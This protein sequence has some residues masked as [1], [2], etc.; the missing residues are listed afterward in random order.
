MTD[1]DEPITA[2]EVIER[3][4]EINRREAEREQELEYDWGGDGSDLHEP[5]RAHVEAALVL[6]DADYAPPLD[7]LLRMGDPRS[8][9]DL[10]ERIAALDLTQAHV[11]D[12]VRMARDRELNIAMSDSDEV[13]APIHALSALEHLD[14]SGV[15]SELVPLFDIDSDWIT[16]DLPGLLSNAGEAALEPVGGYLHDR[17]RWIYGR[18]RAARAIQKIGEQ[19]P[20]LRERAVQILSDDLERAG[21]NYPEMNGFL[22]SELLH[23][24]AVEALPVI[25]RAFEQ[26]AIDETIAGDWETVQQ[27]LGQT[28]DRHDPLVHRS[29]RRWNAKKASTRALLPP[30]LRG[31]DPALP[32]PTAPPKKSGPSKQ[33]AKRKM[34]SAARKTN[35]KKKRK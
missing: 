17:T 10:S 22:L 27:E 26:D 21:E 24:D 32:P 19:Y 11:P 9:T 15:V 1:D 34:A 4:E 12:L 30:T 18:A 33:K 6:T 5:V 13:W 29:R 7:Q 16:D 31:P 23:L 3:I 28:P 2:K 8:Q 14:V 35:K 20:E 25:R